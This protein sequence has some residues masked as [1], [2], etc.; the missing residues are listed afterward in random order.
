MAGLKKVAAGDTTIPGDTWNEMVDLLASLKQQVD[1]VKGSR[2]HDQIKS[3]GLVKVV[4]DS[5]E[6]FGQYHIVGLEEAAFEPVN[7]HAFKQNPP[8]FR[9][10]PPD[11]S[12]VGK[13]AVLLEPLPA[14]TESKSPAALAVASGVV[15]CRVRIDSD[16][17]D[18]ADISPDVLDGA[19]LVSCEKGSA[20]ILWR[21]GNQG[22]I[23]WCIVR[24]SNSLE[25]PCV[26]SVSTTT[27]TTVTTTTGTTAEACPPFDCGDECDVSLE[28]V[29]DVQCIGGAI[30]VTKTT[31]CLRSDQVDL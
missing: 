9:V 20:Q 30:V 1:G 24:L 13:F 11:C 10:V 2:R 25:A 8:Q 16:S 12:H 21:G 3:S 5:E 29:T 15:Q 7:D 31:I 23:Y 26:S 18:Y 14:A 17:H 22:N 6:S 28:V 27:G 4:N 19:N